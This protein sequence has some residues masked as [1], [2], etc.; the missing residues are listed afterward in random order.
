MTLWWFAYGA[1]TFGLIAYG[2]HALVLLAWRRRRGAAY[3]A[4]LDRARAASSLGRST[5]PPVLVQLPIYDEPSV[6]GRAIEALAGLAWPRGR[7]EI[8]VLDDSDDET[9]GIVDAAVARARALD[10]A[11]CIDVVRREHR[12]GF[13][14]GALAAGLERSS[15]PFVAMFD[16]DFVPG[17]DFLVH[18][19]PLFDAADRVACVQGRWV[20]LNRSQNRLT[21][22]Q[23]V[24]VDAHFLVQQFARAAGP[25]LLNF[26]GTAGVWRRAAIDDAGGWCGDTLTEDL[27]LS[28]R[29]Q[30]AG[31]RILFD[32]TL[33]VP[34]ELPPTLG[35]FKSQQ[36]RWACGSMQCARRFLGPVWRSGFP[37][38]RKVEASFQLCGYGVCVAVVALTGLLPLGFGHLPLAI[39]HAWL[40]PLWTTV[41]LAA[42]GPFAVAVVG[43]RAAGRG[44]SIPA[45]VGATLLGLGMC[46][47]NAVA[48]FRGL[49]RPIRT[50]VRTPKQGSRGRARSTSPP[51][52][53]L[54]AAAFSGGSAVVLAANA[55]ATLVPY[56]L[57]CGSGAWALCLYWWFAE[58]ARDL[59]A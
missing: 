40:W 49:V 37:L 35:A 12:A 25:G 43:Q 22:A 10:P 54:A 55:P 13:K 27:D 23:A 56:A 38:A 11:L 3:L 48:V 34:A 24:S 8:Q 21:R 4:R 16:A 39:A 2:L 47:T 9:R 52:I 50:F 41:W 44:V 45:A 18:A 42:C 14:A 33:T 57:F 58:R 15:A 51:R 29:A 26:N 59:R 17:P 19:L 30:L 36:A 53:E 6:A 31:W 7:L 46:A 1:A 28:Y 20:H 5:F 32:P